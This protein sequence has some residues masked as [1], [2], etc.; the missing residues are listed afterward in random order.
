[1]T[2]E[3]YFLKCQQY[4]PLT[5]QIANNKLDFNQI[6]FFIFYSDAVLFIVKFVVRLKW[7]WTCKVVFYVDLVMLNMTQ[8]WVNGMNWKMNCW[9]DIFGLLLICHCYSFSILFYSLFLGILAVKHATLLLQKMPH[10]WVSFELI[11]FKKHED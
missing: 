8:K 3:I 1:M 11:H 9:F 5:P 7:N 10:Q 2:L 6:L 4:V